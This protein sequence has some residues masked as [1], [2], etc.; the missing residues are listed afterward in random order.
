MGFKL[1]FF[2]LITVLVKSNFQ[3]FHIFRK[4]KMSQANQNSNI[5]AKLNS[6]ENAEKESE[7]ESIN[8]INDDASE[9]R[10]LTI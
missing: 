8:K 7:L 10:N 5:E 4:L 2:F 9:E 6:D 1:H 3:L